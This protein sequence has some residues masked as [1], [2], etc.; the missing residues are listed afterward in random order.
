MKRILCWG[1]S[2]TWGY[3]PEDGM[4]YGPGV[5]WT[6][7]L[8]EILGRKWEVIEE[9]L[10][11]RTLATDDPLRPLRNGRDALM[12]SLLSHRPID[13]LILM[14]GTNDVKQRMRLEPSEIGAHLKDIIRELRELDFSPYQVPRRILIIAPAILGPFPLGTDCEDFLGAEEKSRALPEIFQNI[15]QLLGC[16]YFDV[17]SVAKVSP[18]DGLHLDRSGHFALA[19][20][21][22]TLVRDDE[23]NSENKK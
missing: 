15:A 5:R 6:S 23:I 13:L 18:V 1:D 19:E 4:R 20:A 8:Q 22:A 12:I 21:I 2:N 10:N 16:E 9:G 7:R 14:L 17:N 11:G 3:V